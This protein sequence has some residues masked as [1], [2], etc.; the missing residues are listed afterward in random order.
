MMRQE[1][2]TA[3]LQSV[4]DALAGYHLHVCPDH[5][6][7]SASETEAD[8]LRN[9][10]DL[11]SCVSPPDPDGALLDQIYRRVLDRAASEEIDDDE[12]DWAVGAGKK[13][14]IDPDNFK[15]E[16]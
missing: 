9:V 7:R 2:N 13:P 1:N 12:L 10:W 5:Q 8:N 11:V 14:E 15:K 6:D 16:T 3:Y 4:T